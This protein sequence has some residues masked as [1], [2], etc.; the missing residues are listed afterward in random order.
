MGTHQEEDLSSSWCAITSMSTTN[1]VV[2]VPSAGACPTDDTA[3]IL[4]SVRSPSRHSD[5]PSYSLAMPIIPLTTAA[6]AQSHESSGLEGIAAWSSRVAQ[7]HTTWAS[8]Q[9]FINRTPTSTINSCDGPTSRIASEVPHSVYGEAS[10]RGYESSYRS[11]TPPSWA[12]SQTSN[13][14]TPTSTINPCDGP[15]LCWR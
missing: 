1:S 5:P 3:S 8:S 12:S 6:P 10:D 14:R 9:S 7:K 11:A 2:S 15:A 13:N 4:P